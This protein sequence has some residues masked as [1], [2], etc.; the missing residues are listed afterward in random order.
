MNRYKQPKTEWMTK[1]WE[2]KQAICKLV[3]WSKTEGIGLIV[4]KPQNE[5]Y[6]EMF[7][8]VF[9]PETAD[10]NKPVEI[11]LVKN[12]QWII[13]WKSDLEEIND[14]IGIIIA[15]E[16]KMEGM[17]E[18]VNLF[19]CLVKA[20]AIIFH[21]TT[22]DGRKGEFVRLPRESRYNP[23]P[24]HH[25]RRTERDGEIPVSGILRKLSDAVCKVA[26]GTVR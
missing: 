9:S 15:N 2:D 22:P 13:G 12:K 7:Y 1:T 8:F 4:I 19:D 14:I 17:S 18:T 20:N 21:H 6:P 16:M 10:I 3:E 23:I 24:I 5:I 11:A 26:A 25:T